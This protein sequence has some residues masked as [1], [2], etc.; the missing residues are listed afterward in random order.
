MNTVEN[1][2]SRNPL[3]ILII[4]IANRFGD[5]AKEV[6]RFL[7]FAVV[8]GFGALVDFGTL[9]IV[10]ATFL[11][12]VDTLS[13]AGAT[14]IAFCA[15]ILNNFVWNRFWTYPDSR[16]RSVRRQ[17]AL[18]AFISFVGWLGRTIWISFSY[19]TIG[20]MFMPIMLPLIQ[21]A[22]PG[23]APSETAEAKLGT[24]VAMVFGIVVVMF[25]NFFANRYWTYN[26][27]E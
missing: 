6:E 5:R 1:S 13:V 17:L 10:Q 15:A 26:D 2:V 21:L 20:R 8:G 22:R 9:F 23:Y 11:P 7:K 19:H 3:D 12:P 24:I 18:F 27:V 25:W 14:S 16:S 4:T